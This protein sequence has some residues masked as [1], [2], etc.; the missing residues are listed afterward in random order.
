MNGKATRR[1]AAASGRLSVLVVST[2]PQVWGAERSLLGLAPLLEERGIGLALASPPGRLAEAWSALGLPHVEFA[3]PVRQG[4]RTASGGRPGGRGL[5][6][7]IS[8]TV[9]SAR[10][11]AQ[12]ARGADVVHSN[13]LWGHLDCAVAGRIARRPVVL[14]LH[15][16]VLPGLGRHVLRAAVRLASS[17]IAVS[18]AVADTVGA[19]LSRLRVIPQGVDPERFHPGP[20]DASWRAR[21]SSRPDEPIVG[22]VGRVDPEKG[23]RTVVRAMSMLDGP[24]RRSHLAVVGA[25]ALDDGSYE[26]EVRAEASVQ[27]GDRSRFV[28]PVDDVPAVL[29]SLDV[30]VN[31]S[32]SEPFGL[33]VLEA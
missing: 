10:S 21:L 15:D 30:L 16:L 2:S 26:T 5:A 6:R 31:A 33:S 7:E 11:L 24:A 17:A 1:D 23:I 22:V 19:D 9:R 27:L 29:R 4:L 3:A 20:P 25:P 12:L 8:S 13:S 18:Q 28:G 14:E 32:T